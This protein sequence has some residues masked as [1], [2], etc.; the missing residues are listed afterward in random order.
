MNDENILP[1]TYRCD[2]KYKHFLIPSITSLLK[3][4]RGD[5]QI[6]IYICTNDNLDLSE[7]DPLK[8]KY[9]FEYVIVNIDST[10]LH[11]NGLNGSYA[12]FALRKFCGFN[13][14]DAESSQYNNTTYKFNPFNRSKVITG[15]WVFFLAVAKHKKMLCLDTD[16]IIVS[17]INELYNTDVTN[18]V[19]ASCQDWI[20][21]A[22]FNPSVAVIN[23]QKFQE[24]FY[25]VGVQVSEDMTTKEFTKE[26]PFCE[27]FQKLANDLLGKD[28]LLLDKAWNVPITHMEHYPTPKIYHF[29]ESWVGNTKVLTTYEE[30]VNKYLYNVS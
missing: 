5:K 14:F 28:C 11:D 7:L 8:E 23:L 16:T 22:T 18:Y 20:D 25:R 6:R 1:I 13:F 9:P 29:S 17:D 26:E 3:Y 19:L 30:I 12:K 10:F 15:L 24:I 27:S 4:Y 21:T 2:N